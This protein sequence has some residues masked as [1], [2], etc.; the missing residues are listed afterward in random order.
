MNKATI[1]HTI[2]GVNTNKDIKW[3]VAEN[4]PERIVLTNSYDKCV[5][6][7]IKIGA[8][9]ITVRDDHMFHAVEY[10]LK[11]DSRFDDYNNDIDGIKLAI[12]ATV[13]YFNRTY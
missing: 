13:N 1:K 10:L 8:D 9:C 5:K 11:G 3:D 4:T 2:I 12:K 7:T 6:F